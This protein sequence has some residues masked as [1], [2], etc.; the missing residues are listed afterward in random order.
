MNH[1]QHFDRRA[2]TWDRMATDET[3]ASLGQIVAGLGIAPGSVVLDMGTG[4][5]VLL[6]MLAE[7]VGEGGLVLALDI[8]GEMLRRARVKASPGPTDYLQADGAALPLREASL[9]LI[10]CNACFPHLPDKHRAAVEMARALRPGG[11]LVICHTSGRQ[12]IN[13]LH[14]SLGGVVKDDM[15]PSGQELRRMMAEAGFVD[16]E[17]QDEPDRFVAIALRPAQVAALSL[18]C[19]SLEGRCPEHVEGSK[20]GDKDESDLDLVR[21]LLMDKGLAFVVVKGG[22]VIA[23]SKEEGVGPFFRA[24]ATKRDELKGAALAD[25]VV[26][27]AVVLLSLYAGIAAIYTPLASEPALKV[28]KGAIAINADRVVPRILNKDGT[29]LC[30]FEALTAAIDAPEEAFATLRSFFS[31]SG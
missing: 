16:I 26:G 18:R 1:R 13:R 7:A 15:L 23:S 28:L 31:R 3:L 17:V 12:V 14:R 25:K 27:R 21:Q 11:R 29:G 8:S 10:V 5:G 19:P 22:R 20:G 6:P 4:T 9:D 24:V 2:A 30:P